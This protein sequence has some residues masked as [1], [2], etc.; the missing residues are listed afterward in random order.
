MGPCLVLEVRRDPNDDRLR[1]LYG[2]AIARR[3]R[4]GRLL[5]MYGTGV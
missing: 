4:T 2:L 1:G 5:V 3:G